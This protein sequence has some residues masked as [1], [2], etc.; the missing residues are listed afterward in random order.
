MR[1]RSYIHRHHRAANVVLAALLA[2]LLLAACKRRELY[3]YGDEFYSVILNVDWRDFDS[4][5]PDGM[6]VWFYSLDDP[7]RE[8]YRTT[9]ANVRRMELYLPNG[10]YQGVVVSYSP[11]EY[12]RQ[13]FYDMNDINRARVEATIASYQ[14]EEMRIAGV[15]ISNET[16]Q[17]V[18]EALFGDQVWTDHMTNHPLNL[19]NGYHA[20]V[21]QPEAMGA[22]T[23]DNRNVSSGSEFGD[24]IPWKQRDYYQ[25][26]LTVRTINSVP[27][28]LVWTL[29][30]RVWI[31]EGF[32]Y[33]WQPVATVSGLANG[34][35]LPWHVNTEVPCL[36]SIDSWETQRTGNNEGFVNATITCFGLRPSSRREDAV[37]HSTT[38]TGKS[39]Y[40]GREC[41]LGAY[42]S[43]VCNPMELRLN[44]AF[45][46]RD[47]AT[48]VTRS[49][50]CGDALLSYDDQMVLRLEL[51]QSYLWNDPIILPY[52]DAYDG[53]GFDAD[54]TPW[55]DVEPVDVD[56]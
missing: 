52:V 23:L 44:L 2:I 20:V 30:V 34:H 22:D 36:L 48:V 12:S 8:P 31:K 46:L 3:V 42:Y 4:S 1:I 50:N 49:F 16:D 27:H 19:I 25:S 47:Q 54:V 10:R 17:K 9:T 6:T 33:L 35:F 56:F 21:S 51:D 5:D 24:Y 15:G 41:D 40:D 55:V 14:P 37:L 32:D 26:T 11:D 7:T 45:I 43:N 53:A 38:E 29:R 18:K 28:S 39:V 13:A